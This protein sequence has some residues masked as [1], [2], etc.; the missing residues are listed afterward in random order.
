MPPHTS[1]PQSPHPQPSSV[2]VEGAECDF[3]CRGRQWLV[4]QHLIWYPEISLC[5]RCRQ[6]S[7]PRL[8]LL[9][10]Y[11]LCSCFPKQQEFYLVTAAC[12]CSFSAPKFV[13]GAS[14]LSCQ[15]D[16]WWT[17]LLVCSL[18][19]MG[20][21]CVTSASVLAVWREQ[22]CD[23][24]ECVYVFVCVWGGACACVCVHLCILL[25]SYRLLQF[26]QVILSVCKGHV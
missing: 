21:D 17:K 16:S 8:L 15:T 5:D 18:H 22:H 23:C 1:H 13:L 4:Y 2:Y 7:R 14:L 24:F 12:N 9:H 20:K 19:A 25:Y 26:V 6:S 3:D 10:F 11:W